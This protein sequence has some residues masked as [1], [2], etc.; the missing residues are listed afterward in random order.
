MKLLAFFLISIGIFFPLTYLHARKY[1]FPPGDVDAIVIDGSNPWNP[2]TPNNP[3]GGEAPNTPQETES[4][5]EDPADE[6]QDTDVGEEGGSDAGE[7][8]TSSGGNDSES[9]ESGTTGGSGNTGSGGTS[10][11]NGDDE[12]SGGGSEE[13]SLFLPFDDSDVGDEGGDG[14]GGS[15][16]GEEEISVPADDA[17]TITELEEYNFF[18]NIDVDA[19]KQLQSGGG[20]SRAIRVLEVEKASDL[21]R[22][23]EDVVRSDDAIVG[24][25]IGLR[26]I[27][28]D[29][30]Q[31]ARLFGFIPISYTQKVQVTLTES[32][33]LDDVILEKPWWLFFAT[34][35]DTEL[36][37]EQIRSEVQLLIAQGGQLRD[38]EVRGLLQRLAAI[39]E[40]IVL[41]LRDFGSSVRGIFG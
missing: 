1:P 15:G 28:V 18:I 4:P 24:A 33:Q 29:Y 35:D 16:Q 37:R 34:G 39:F 6:Q 17:E 10:T 38:E 36:L 13:D 25:N 21:V 26:E 14:S 31:P 5:E 30:R 9:D 8:E 3:S 20:N 11:Q 23:V 27:S 12:T 41:M 40:R 2:G 22:F 7:S 32:Y 19:A